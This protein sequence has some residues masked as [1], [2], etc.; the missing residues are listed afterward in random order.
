MSAYQQSII[1]TAC[2][3]VISVS[4]VFV[5]TSLAGMFSMGQAAFLAI[6]AYITF[7]LAKTLS[8]PLILTSVIGIGMS[9]LCAYIISIPTLKLRK[10]YFSLI[11]MGFGEMITAVV[12]LFEKYT[13]GSIGYSRIPKV[14]HLFWI[15]IGLTVLVVFCVWNLK[16]SRFGRMCIALKTDEVAARSF[17][18][19]VYKVKI[20]VYV[21]ASAIAGLAGILYG[22]RNRVIMPDSFNWN[23]SAEMQIF[24]FFGGTNSLTGAVISAILLKILPEFFRTI[25][26]FGQSLQEYRTIIYCILILVVINFRPKGMFGEKEF[27]V[28][29][30]RRRLKRHPLERVENTHDK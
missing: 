28:E 18:I 13:N 25:K 2:I 10:D 15:V 22:L 6:S 5:I 14:H 21:F 3:S 11:T 29:A 23:L 8:L 26:I 7:I 12:I 16:K 9:A 20:K 1:M 30:L 27:S 17:G 19:D 4:G 24:L